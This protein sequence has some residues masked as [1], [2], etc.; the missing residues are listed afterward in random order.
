MPE[1]EDIEKEFRLAANTG[2]I[3]KVRK[4]LSDG[5]SVDNVNQVYV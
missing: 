3:D 2:E 4:S 1:V 5:V